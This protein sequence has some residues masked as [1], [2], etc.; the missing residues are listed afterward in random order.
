MKGKDMI[1][2]QI[3][4]GRQLVVGML[5][6]FGLYLINLE[7]YLLFH[8]LGEVFSIVVAGGIFM[9]SWNSRQFLEDGFSC[10]W[11]SRTCSSAGWIWSTRWRTEVW[12]YSRDSIRTCQPSSGS[13][14]GTS[15]A[16]LY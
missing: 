4:K 15:K 16:S 9:V 6:L 8:S 11:A 3:A 5:I 1:R 7:N 12:E 10:C 14:A 2:A 13:S